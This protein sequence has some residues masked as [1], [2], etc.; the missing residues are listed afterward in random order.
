[1][2]ACWVK[3]FPPWERPLTVPWWVADSTLDVLRYACLPTGKAFIVPAI[4]GAVWLYRRGNRNFV[5]FLVA[6]IALAL[7]ASCLHAYPYGGARV[8][9]Y[10]CP[11]VFILVA[12]GTPTCVS[13]LRSRSRIVAVTI[14]ALLV[15]PAGQCILHVLI[16][17]GRADCAG[18]AHYVK[19]HRSAS[20]VVLGNGWE[21]LYYFRNMRDVY[22]PLETA[23]FPGPTRV[24]LILTGA[25]P[26]ER[27]DIADHLAAIQG[28]ILDAR[29]FERTKVVLLDVGPKP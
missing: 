6:P 17:W 13:W 1:M 28:P 25:T 14:I 16:P 20:D 21:Y 3:M 22:Q 7:V 4:I 26:Q 29:D 12:A 15:M 18:A 11:A 5:V 24:W 9:V 10:A 8:L 27:V 2:D 19:A 23:P